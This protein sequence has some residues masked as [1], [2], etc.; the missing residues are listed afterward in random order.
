MVLAAM[1]SI[2]RETALARLLTMRVNSSSGM[3]GRV[4]F[5]NP[6]CLLS[7]VKRTPSPEPGMSPCDSQETSERNQ[8]TAA[9]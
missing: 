2:V 7:R 6:G 1:R 8:P 9:Y 4:Y 5:I 3:Q